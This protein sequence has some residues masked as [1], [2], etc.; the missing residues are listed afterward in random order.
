[1]RIQKYLDPF[2]IPTQLKNLCVLIDNST[3]IFANY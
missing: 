1:M 3:N 2:S